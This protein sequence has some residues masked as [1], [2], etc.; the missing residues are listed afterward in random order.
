MGEGGIKGGAVNCPDT[1][2]H[3]SSHQT[4]NSNV[5]EA[6]K[7]AGN[8]QGEDKGNNANA[9]CK[10]CQREP[11]HNGRDRGWGQ[12]NERRRRTTTD[13]DNGQ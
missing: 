8:A 6:S 12:H 4:S 3:I 10:R 11:T 2:E 7:G 13:D 1:P 5:E 9:A